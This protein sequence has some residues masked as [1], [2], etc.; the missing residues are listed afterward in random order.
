MN[1]KRADHQLASVCTGTGLQLDVLRYT[2]P[3]NL[4]TE[5]DKFFSQLKK[6]Q[7]YN[8]RFSYILPRINIELIRRRLSA[9]QTDGSALGRVLA[10]KKVEILKKV[11]LVKA[12]ATPLL[13][14]R[15][16]DLWSTP[17]EN[18]IK[19]AKRYVRIT[20]SEEKPTFSAADV[21]GIIERNLKKYRLNWGVRLAQISSTAKISSE[22]RALLLNPTARFSRQK[23]QSLIV[24]EVGTHILRAENARAQPY[25]IFSGFPDYLCTEEG[26]AILNEELSRCLNLE[27]IRIIAGRVL[28]VQ[29][30]LKASFFSTFSKLLKLGFNPVETWNLTLR[31]KRGLSDTSVPGA[32]TKDIIYLKG[33]RLLKDWLRSGGNL[34]KLYY[35]KIGTTHVELL[36]QVP[37]LN[38]QICLPKFEF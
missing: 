6:G 32:L 7:Q 20:A 4:S 5:H 38:R 36:D 26:L 30:S 12:I 10:A 11:L 16:A 25:L 1:L 35:G 31:S 24:H 28:A 9:I 19:T 23:I 15:S 37:G 8:P 33:E 34:N 2:T 27:R 21:K 18:L 13:T 3:V 14:Q 17:D 29:H 22:Q